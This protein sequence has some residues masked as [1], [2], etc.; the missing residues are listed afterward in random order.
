MPRSESL[1]D[2]LNSHMYT[3]NYRDDNLTREQGD[4]KMQFNTPDQ[5]L[6]NEKQVFH[7]TQPTN[8]HDLNM[9]EIMAVPTQ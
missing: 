8:Y 4:L 1:N 3:S 9:A 6:M 5:V 7:K 2:T